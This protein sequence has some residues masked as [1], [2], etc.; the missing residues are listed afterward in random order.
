MAFLGQS[1][2]PLVNRNAIL[3]YSAPQMFALVNDVEAYPDFLPWCKASKII[4]QT[5]DEVC[6]SLTLKKGAI[7]K[8]FTTCNRIQINKMIEVKLLNGPFKH[9]EGFW[10]FEAISESSCRVIL[11]L[12]FEFAN[13]FISLAFGAVFQQVTQTLI[14][15]FIERAAEKYG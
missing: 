2:M 1:I 6:A 13:K 14:D 8:D 9:L 3:P 11:N 15:A 5:T 7:E 10:Q 12:E 4:K